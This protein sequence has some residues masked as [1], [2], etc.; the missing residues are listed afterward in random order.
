MALLILL[1]GTLSTTTSRILKTSVRMLFC[2]PAL[3]L[4]H[5]NL[6]NFLKEDFSSFKRE[7]M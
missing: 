5:E 4:L 2:S 6:S 1:M 3:G 7:K